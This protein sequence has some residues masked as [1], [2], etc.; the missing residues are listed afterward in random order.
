M[1]LITLLY[2]FALFVLF[3]PNV[4]I[5]AP[6]PY[7]IIIHSVCFALFLY[8]TIDFI[9]YKEKEGA[10]LNAYDVN[11]NKYDIEATN[12]DLG[13][14]Q[15]E[16]SM[17][18]LDPQSRIIYTTV[19]PKTESIN[20]IPPLFTRYALNDSLE[21][22][23]HHHHEEKDYLTNIYCAANYGENTTCCG[24]PSAEVPTENQCPKHSPICSG[25]VAFETWGQCVSNNDAIPKI[26]YTPKSQSPC[27]NN[28]ENCPTWKQCCPGGSGSTKD[29]KCG[30]TDCPLNG[31]PC[32]GTWMKENCPQTCNLCKNGNIWDGNIGGKY[33]AEEKVKEGNDNENHYVTIKKTHYPNTYVWTNN[34]NVSYVLQRISNTQEYNVVGDES[35][36]WLIA[37]VHLD[38]RNHVKYIIGANNVIFTKQS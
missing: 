6:K 18:S 4:F 31:K 27:E 9:Q 7:T 20:D 13:D 10:I 17:S 2:I 35:N 5:K 28:N 14:V 21:K 25:Y 26:E 16:Q 19:A 1:K 37:K 8:F 3:S 33:I 11:G 12:V 30:T 32:V 36:G 34:R 38:Y 22:V 24:Q 23:M 15:M 29:I